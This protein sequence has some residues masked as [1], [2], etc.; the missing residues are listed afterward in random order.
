MSKEELEAAE[1]KT[2]DKK[3]EDI[4]CEGKDCSE[5]IDGLG[6]IKKGGYKVVD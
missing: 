2:E 5:D 1:K 4:E 3:E 6:E